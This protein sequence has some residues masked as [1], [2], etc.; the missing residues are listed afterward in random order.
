MFKKLWKFILAA[1]LAGMLLG[2]GWLPQ[3]PAPEPP[4]P[5]NEIGD[6]AIIFENGWFGSPK[7]WDKLMDFLEDNGYRRDYMFPVTVVDNSRLCSVK[8]T[9]QL[10]DT[11]DSVRLT[12]GLDKVILIGHSRGGA[13]L[14][15]F[16]HS[17]PDAELVSDVIT[18]AGANSI[19]CIPWEDDDPT[20]AAALYTSIYSPSD[21][22][23]PVNVSIIEG[24]WNISIDNVIH[25]A[26][27]SNEEVFELVLDAIENGGYN[28]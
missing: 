27:V 19:Q 1:S 14:M 5:V 20:P 8:H 3:P 4:P 24:A 12:T 23:L 17:S 15:D 16:M 22:L 26:F 21:G 28:N 2:M 25:T 9:E 10:E 13:V 11:I 6:V 7:N 18:L